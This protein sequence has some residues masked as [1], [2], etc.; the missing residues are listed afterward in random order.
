MPRPACLAKNHGTKGLAA[1]NFAINETKGCEN[2]CIGRIAP[3]SATTACGVIE[4][5][6][7]FTDGACRGN[8]GPGGWGVLSGGAAEGDEGCTV[9]AL[10]HCMRLCFNNSATGCRCAKRGRCDADS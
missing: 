1:R 4:P 9:S 5:V 10:M 8:P 6:L 3:L 2:G 7:A